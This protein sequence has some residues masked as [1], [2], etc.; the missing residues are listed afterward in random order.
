MDGKRPHQ[1]IRLDTRLPDFGDIFRYQITMFDGC[2]A[3]GGTGA[4]SNRM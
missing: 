3:I 4:A 2:R 1:E